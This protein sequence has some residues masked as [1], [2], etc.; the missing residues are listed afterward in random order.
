MRFSTLGG[1]IT[2]A[3]ISVQA[4][5]TIHS[6]GSKFFDSNGN[7]FYIKGVSY[8]LVPDDPLINV[9]QCKLD[10]ALMKTLGA[11]SI[12]VYHVDPNGK[13]DDCMS[14]FADAG[15]YLWLDLD[16]F[17]SQIEQPS[18]HWNQTQL[19]AF[20]KVMDAFHN[21]DNTAGFLVGNEVI[22]TANGSVAAPFVKA[23]ARDV[24]AYRNAKGYRNIPVGYAAADIASLRPMLQNYLACGTNAS[25]AV[26]YY[27]LNAYEWCGA[28]SY[29]QSGYNLITEQIHD[30]NVPIFFSETGCNTVPP[31]TWNDQ[32]AIFGPDMAPYWSGS[33]IYE[34]IEEQN[35]YGIV[36]YGPKVD[37][38][39]A[40]DGFPRSGTP[41]PVVPDFTNLANQ[42]KTLTPSGVKESAYN[43]TLTAPACPAQTPGVWEVNGNVPLPTLGQTYGAAA[44]GGSA[45]ATAT[46]A[47]ASASATKA[48]GAS[49]AKEIKGMGLGLA[50]VLVGFFWWMMIDLIVVD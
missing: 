22:T 24:K 33:I 44:V 29:T 17:S 12:R 40:P 20:E 19:S 38:S 21:Y 2:A 39:L 36:N 8:Q 3:A 45:T 13:H 32:A 4:I 35:N 7:Q 15:I 18:P 11:N 5:P 10:A 42:W 31:R 34:W 50:G 49:P 48:G 1:L 23:A 14:A 37:P 41:T 27:C 25:E 16:T 28:S 26:D 47:K 6:K 46:G 30:Y 9:T 43:P